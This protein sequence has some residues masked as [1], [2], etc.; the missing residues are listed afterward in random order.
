MASA[1]PR[2]TFGSHR[3]ITRPSRRRASAVVKIETVSIDVF[4]GELAQPP[5]L[6]LE[7]FNDSCASRAQFFVGRVD[8]RRKY[9]MD[10]RFER[11]ASSAKENRYRFA[12]DGSDIVL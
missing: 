5:R 2:A 3:T 8:V 7:R 10:S 11:A 1:G 4:H 9:P 12:R 6:L